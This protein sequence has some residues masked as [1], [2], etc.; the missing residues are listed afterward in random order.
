MSLYS[1]GTPVKE[2]GKLNIWA[3]LAF[4]LIVGA[5]LG[6]GV[7]VLSP[8]DFW[9]GWLASTVLL[10]PALFLLLAACEWG[11]GGRMLAW[12]VGLAF[13]LRL[14]SGIGLSLALPA[15]GYAEKEQ[16]AGYLFKDAYNRDNEAWSLNQSGKPVWN[17][18]VKEFA[19]DQY[20]G[21]LAIS[22]L[23]YRTFSPDMHRPFLIL[24]LSAF[25]AAIGVPFLWM[26]VHLRWARRVTVLA[27]WIYVFYPDAVYF[28]S[29]QMREPFLVGLSAVAFWA[30]LALNLRKRSTW[31][32]LGGSLLCMALISSRVA[33]AVAGLLGLLF[34]IENIIGR[35]ERR[36]K[37]LGW[38]ALGAGV[39]LM[40]AF[41][42]EWFRNS[43]GWEMLV[44]RNS[45]GRVYQNIKDFK[46]LIRLSR[47]EINVMFIVGYG[48]T[49]PLLPAAIAETAGSALWK[50][51]AIVRSLGW[52]MLAPFLIYGLF[53][54]WKE[55]DVRV[56]RRSIWLV[57]VVILWLL[58]ASA[59]G[60]GDVTDNPR[61]RSQFIVWLA[62]LAAWSVDWALAHRD[63]WLWRWI[64][65]E[66]IFLGFFTNWYFSRY[67]NTWARLPFWTMIAWIVGLS[68]L[69][70]VGG[71]VWD[72]WHAR[73]VPQLPSTEKPTSGR[74]GVV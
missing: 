19:T 71:W 1:T 56:R 38:V 3:R 24:I 22:A 49:R 4:A 13:L 43:V 41:S 18:F 66:A 73:K 55:R 51:I 27:T 40:L 44:T 63:A 35:P 20:G 48:L 69:V 12:L 25:F 10:A 16:Q 61:Y 29:S 33:A 50:G 36:W 46:K 47:D 6:A 37:I 74:S 58:I 67:F 42:L 17:S 45:S 39:L 68:G 5:L 28:S 65:V 11:G 60:G 21:L 57:L 14:A 59:R 23:V 34:L 53:W 70:L 7:A 2:S 64:G 52:Y 15:W 72:R 26:A 32:A 30:L 8:G 54:V 31:L 9:R 62:L